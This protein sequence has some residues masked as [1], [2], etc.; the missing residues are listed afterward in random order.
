MGDR[1]FQTFREAGLSNPRL[2]LMS[3]IG[4]GLEWDGYAYAA[5]TVRSLLP[6]ILKAGLASADEIGI[7]TLEERL[8]T[9]TEAANGV[10]RLPEL[11]SAWASVS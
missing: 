4:G 6:L 10:I 2:C 9:E 1:L 8:R 5:A 7:D 3:Y 11:I